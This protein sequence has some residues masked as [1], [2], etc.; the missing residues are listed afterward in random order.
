MGVNFTTAK[1]MT[2]QGGQEGTPGRIKIQ[3][4]KVALMPDMMQQQ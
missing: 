4:V 3:K 2:I 1:K